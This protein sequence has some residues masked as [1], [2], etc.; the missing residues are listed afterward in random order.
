VFT[1]FDVGV[2]I[3]VC[4]KHKTSTAE[5][6]GGAVENASVVPEVEYVDLF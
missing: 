3:L 2:L 1:E 5:V 4:V 6:F